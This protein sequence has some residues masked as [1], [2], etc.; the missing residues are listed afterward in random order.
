MALDSK[1]LTLGKVGCQCSSS[2]SILLIPKPS[3][4]ILRCR[5]SA[6]RVLGYERKVHRVYKGFSNLKTLTT[7]D[8]VSPAQVTSK[9]SDVHCSLLSAL[10]FYIFLTLTLYIHSLESSQQFEWSMCIDFTATFSVILFS[11]NV[12]SQFPAFGL[13]SIL[14]PQSK[15]KF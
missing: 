14:L 9:L 10:S 15:P 13:S 5:T 1:N 11:K 2:Y 3:F 12:G 7:P 8:S 6:A 4:L